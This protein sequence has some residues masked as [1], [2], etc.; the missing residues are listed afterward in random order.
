ME[1]RRITSGA[2]VVPQLSRRVYSTARVSRLIQV[3][4]GI[5]VFFCVMTARVSA[6][7]AE[8]SQSALSEAQA[9]A[10]FLYNCVMFVDW[11]TAPDAAEIVIG[12]IG[13][14]SIASVIDGMQGRKVNGRMLRVKLVRPTDD[15][16]AFHILYLGGDD[17]RTAV[18]LLGKIGDAPV[19]TVGER[20]D[21]TTRGGVVRLYTDRDRLRF[22]INMTSAERAGLRVSAKMLGL[23]KI[24]R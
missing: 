9:K 14:D 18:A 24:V 12:I 10:G 2:A 19:L 7:G 5:A 22:E 16:K 1:W 23:A 4:A 11:P 20:D 3:C 8:T 13:A 15:P 6:G 21:F 17:Q